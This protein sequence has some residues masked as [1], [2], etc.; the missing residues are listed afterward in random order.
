MR[1]HIA[2]LTLVL[3]A[4]FLAT[5]C[6]AGDSRFTTDAG[7]DVTTANDQDGDTISDMDE[8]RGAGTDTDGDTVPDYLDEDSDGD[9]IPDQF[10]AGDYDSE[11]PPADS[12][13]DGTPDFRDLD[14]DGN[15]VLD[16][17]EG[18][19]DADGDGIADYADIDNDG[20]NID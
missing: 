6:G 13:A 8:G 20:D 19:G 7:T 17:D 18:F 5:G 2:M 9:T 12:D 10:E 4:A 16:I 11:T 3:S 1:T 15:G 14:S